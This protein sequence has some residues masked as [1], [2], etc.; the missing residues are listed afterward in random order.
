[1]AKTPETKAQKSSR[2]NDGED[3]GAMTEEEVTFLLDQEEAKQNEIAKLHSEWLKKNKPAEDTSQSGN[4]WTADDLYMSGSINEVR[5]KAALRRAVQSQQIEDASSS[6]NSIEERARAVF[7]EYSDS[8]LELLEQEGSLGRNIDDE[9]D[10]HLASL[11]SKFD[12]EE[13]PVAQRV[14][15]PLFVKYVKTSRQKFGIEGVRLRTKESIEKSDVFEQ[16]DHLR[17]NEDSRQADV[18]HAPD[19]EVLQQSLVAHFREALGVLKLDIEAG[20]AFANTVLE[21]VFQQ[22]SLLSPPTK[23]P[24]QYKQRADK[25]ERPDSFIRREYAAWIEH[26]QATA[27]PRSVFGNIDP[28]LYN[29][30]SRYGLSNELDTRFPKTSGRPKKMGTEQDTIDLAKRR[31]NKRNRMR[32]YRAKTKKIDQ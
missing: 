24:A 16:N 2:K 17:D 15:E 28:P 31:E 6:R 18:K 10:E 29:A 9:L 1:M 3:R 21:Q 4:Q 7:Y 26:P 25:Q 13:I 8:L 11:V 5:R 27:F 19:A 14:L 30:I 12:E 32:R 20:R 22:T 23:A